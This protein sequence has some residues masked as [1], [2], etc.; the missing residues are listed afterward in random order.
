M[1]RFD[2]KIRINIEKIIRLLRENNVL[3]WAQVFERFLRD[4]N[5]EQDKKVVIRSIVNV[6]KGGMGS[7]SDLVLQKN[8]KMLIEENNQLATLNDELFNDCLHNLELNK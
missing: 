7:F 2:E 8:M 5:T 6:Y 1:E 3:D 4:F